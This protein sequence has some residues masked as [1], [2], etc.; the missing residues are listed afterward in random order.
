MC[1]SVAQRPVTAQKSGANFAHR[2]RL[3]PLSVSISIFPHHKLPFFHSLLF[4]LFPTPISFGGSCTEMR[5]NL[6]AQSPAS[7]AV[8]F[9]VPH[10]LPFF[11]SLFF[12]QFPTPNSL[13]S[14]RA[15]YA[16]N[17]LRIL[18]SLSA[19]AMPSAVRGRRGPSPGVKW[20]KLRTV[21]GPPAR[22]RLKASCTG[23]RRA[24]PHTPG[25]SGG[26]SRVIRVIAP[27]C[28]A[29]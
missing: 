9:P 18:H 10:L 19:P 24:A 21:G 17:C 14:F 12:T 26:M 4:T 11:H 15:G 6:C 27:W 13:F 1:T 2:F 3:K 28:R 22:Q 25:V 23:R 8:R 7:T 16:F 20:P 29:F 5:R